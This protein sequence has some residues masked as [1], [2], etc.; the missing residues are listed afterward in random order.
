MSLSAHPCS[1][2]LPRA[3]TSGDF[4]LGVRRRTSLSSFV[5]YRLHGG[6]LAHVRKK[7]SDY[8]RFERWILVLVRSRSS[9]VSL[10]G[11]HV[12]HVNAVGEHRLLVGL[13]YCSVGV[14][15]TGFGSYKQL[16]GLLFIQNA[17]AHLLIASGI[18]LGVV[19]G[20]ENAFTVP[21]VYGGANG[22]TWL[23][24]VAHLAAAILASVVAWLVG[25]V[26][27]FI[28]KLIQP[29]RLPSQ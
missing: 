21:E 24:V 25:S 18:L 8:V 19:T 20:R 12:I 6:Y 22:A 5:A 16:F 1:V 13:I 14:H 9:C 7:F 28:T 17:F 29:R 2:D 11:R 26:I 3:H 4:Q 15:T 27:L 23:H 10:S